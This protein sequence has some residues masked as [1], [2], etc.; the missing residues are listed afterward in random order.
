MQ[1]TQPQQTDTQQEPGK[2]TV[3]LEVP[4]RPGEYSSIRVESY[5]QAET[6]LHG[7]IERTGRDAYYRKT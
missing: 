1:Q 7:Y 5:M 6:L 3:F 4:G 2:Y